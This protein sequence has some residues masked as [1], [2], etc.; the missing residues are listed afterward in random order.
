MD[1]KYIKTDY[2]EMVTGGDKEL[3]KELIMMFNKQVDEIYTEMINYLSE[4]NYKALGQLA[5]KAK[6]SVAIMGMDDLAD[7]LK[8]FELKAGE[9]TD[10]D[11][12][13]SF[14]TRFGKDTSYAVTE[15]E[16]LMNN[17]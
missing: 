5:H 9:G 2:L 3:R 4:K 14:I 17:G 7:M 8:L 1:Y 12:Y 10:T 16:H 15:L 13:E 6:S 11:Q